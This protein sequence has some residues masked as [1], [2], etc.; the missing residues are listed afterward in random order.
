[1]IKDEY[2][3]V[4]QVAY[5]LKEKRTG[6][7]RLLNLKKIPYIVR[8]G[9]RLILVSDL[10]KY[11][12]VKKEKY[13][14]A[15]AYFDAINKSSFWKEQDTNFYNRNIVHSDSTIENLTISQ[16]AYLLNLSRQAV[17]G[18]VKRGKMKKRYVE[19]SRQRNPIICIQEDE[20]ENYVKN[21]ERKFERAIEFFESK[22]SSAFWESHSADFENEY[23]KP[24]K[25]I[26]KSYYEK[27]KIQ[28]NTC[29]TG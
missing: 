29:Q 13:R 20:V 24:N 7:D 17:Y 23:I 11:V 6:V 8:Q 16:V 3:L 22:D 2:L 1:M 28:K 21:R 10:K 15:H 12:A 25:E 27:K 4:S 19:L 9:N 26:N 5:L 14:M 18:L